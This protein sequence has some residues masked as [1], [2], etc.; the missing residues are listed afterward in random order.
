MSETVRMVLVRGVAAAKASAK[1]EARFYL[2]KALNLDATSDQRAK[3]WLWLSKISSDPIEKREC[4]ETALSYNPA[5]PTAR[6]ELAILDGSLEPEEVVNP[7]QLSSADPQAPR[8]VQA[9]RFICHQCGGKMTFAPNG[10]ALTC[11]YCDR[12]LTLFQAIQEGAMVEEQDFAVA[13]ATVEGHTHPVTMQSITCRGCGVTFVLAPE[14]LSSN[15]PYC[16]SA[17]VVEEADLEELIPPEGVIPFAWTKERARQAALR[18]LEDINDG[19]LVASP[20][21]VYFPVWTFDLAGEV[22]WHYQ[23]KANDEWIP[24]RGSKVVYEDDLVIPASHALP[25]SLA[26]E[27]DEFDLA[28]VIP[29]DPAYLADWPA[30]TYE[31][32]VANASLV[33]RQQIMDDLRERVTYGA[34]GATKGLTMN[35]TRLVVE[36]FKLLLLPLWIVHYRDREKKRYIIVVN[37]QT[38]AVRGEEP[39]RGIRKLLGWLLGE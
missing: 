36:S 14:T 5:H 11:S 4:L 39:P 33:A 29:Y 13:L 26:Q 8:S 6:R 9:R 20:R 15:C 30:E 19:H 25:A 1:G 32:P 31:I 16:A 2:E 7:D 34:F 10:K 38:G 17:Y 12:R 21:G 35:S 23:E 18:W 27:V 24:R 22:P 37:G 3:A 28:G